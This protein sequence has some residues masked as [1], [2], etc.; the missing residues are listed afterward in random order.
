MD[1]WRNEGK[2]DTTEVLVPKVVKFLETENVVADM[3]D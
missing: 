2:G 1:K 3:R